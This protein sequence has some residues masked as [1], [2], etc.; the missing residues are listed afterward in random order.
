MVVKTTGMLLHMFTSLQPSATV[1]SSSRR[2]HVSGTGNSF[3]FTNTL[4]PDITY[5]Q[6]PSP[7]THVA[8]AAMMT[9]HGTSTKDQCCQLFVHDHNKL[10]GSQKQK[11]GQLSYWKQAITSGW[12]DSHIIILCNTHYQEFISW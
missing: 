4:T 2:V 3:P 1:L 7:E 11:L 10:L 12:P 8:K 5:T 9:A 6:I